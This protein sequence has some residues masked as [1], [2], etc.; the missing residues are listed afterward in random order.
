MINATE[1]F[2]LG[3]RPITF[4]VLPFNGAEAATDQ[5]SGPQFCR[6]IPLAFTFLE[7]SPMV[8]EALRSRLGGNL[9][10]LG[11]DQQ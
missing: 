9:R 5:A 11:L 4:Q 6:G 1:I 8:A 10:I 3:D 2:F 7:K